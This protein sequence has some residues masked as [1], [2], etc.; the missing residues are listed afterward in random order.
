MSTPQ[1]AW[2]ETLFG[3]DP[4]TRRAAFIPR[5]PTTIICACC[6][7]ATMITRRK[8]RPERRERHSPPRRHG[9]DRGLIFASGYLLDWGSAG[10]GAYAVFRLGRDAFGGD[11]A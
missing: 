1:L 5:L 7:S 10:L 8:D 4:S 11:L 3:T 9:L 6:S 2:C